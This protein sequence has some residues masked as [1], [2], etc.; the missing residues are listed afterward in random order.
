MNHNGSSL[1]NYFIIYIL[2]WLAWIGLHSLILINNGISIYPALTDSI[3]SNTLLF[4]LCLMVTNVLRFYQPGRSSSR[5]LFLWCL[6]LAGLWF[7]IMKFIIISLLGYDTAFMDLFN[8]TLLLRLLLAVMLIGG[9]I[10]LM[11]VWQNIQSQKEEDRLHFQALKTAKDAELAS[12]RQQLQPH[13]LFNSLN[14]ISALAGSRPEQARLMIQQLSDFLRGTLHKDESRFVT[15]SEELAHLKLY[16]DIEKV[17]FGH[18]LNTV[19]DIAGE[20]NACLLPP[21]L[22]QPIVE[23]AIK[24]GLYDTLEAVTISISARIEP[25]GLLVEVRNPF[26][27]SASRPNKGTGFGL[28]S[29][30]RRLFLLYS[31]SDLLKTRA[32]GPVFFTTLTIPQASK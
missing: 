30:S 24:F 29:V 4:V 9:S 11:W 32:E 2:M 27:E 13:F 23:N 17:R 31:R 1:R 19:F 3:V 12:L 26:D 15:L 21:L 28:N 14:S 6:I 16:L 25:D 8:A 22:L 7:F 5:Y 10:L 20:C 18:R